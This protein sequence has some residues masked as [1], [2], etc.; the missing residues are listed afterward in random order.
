[1]FRHQV[2][3]SRYIHNLNLVGVFR[4]INNM[5]PVTRKELAENSKYSAATVSNHVKTLMQKGFVIETEKGHSTGGRKPVYLNVNPEKGYIISIEIQVNKVKLVIFNLKLNIKKSVEINI[6]N[7]NKPPL[8]L[9]SILSR[10]RKVLTEEKLNQKK[11]LGIG[12]AIPGLVEKSDNILQFAPNLGWEQVDIVKHFSEYQVP[13]ILENEANAAV[14]GEKEFIYPQQ[15]NMVYVSINEGIG[16]GIIFNG[17]LYPGASGNAGEFGHIIIDNEGRKCHCGNRGCWETL[18][19]INYII[20]EYKEKTGQEIKNIKEINHILKNQKRTQL[21]NILHRT[22]FNI[23]LGLVNIINS[24]SPEMLIIGGNINL[25]KSYIEN[26]I[27]NI[28]EKKALSI[29]SKKL[30]LQFS[31][32]NESAAVHGLASIVFDESISMIKIR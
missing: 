27:L 3:N 4:L 25:F 24:L 28:I 22:G 12:I 11:I 13:I 26:E 8:V 30:D 31:K 7:K 9:N 21:I 20:N 5:G 23:G 19:S 29:S 32:L 14:V 2:G 18:A 1:M 17:I 10:L 16:C 15:Q 6:Q